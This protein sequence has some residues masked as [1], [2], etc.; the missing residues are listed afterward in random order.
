MQKEKLR[1]TT[2][3][4]KILHVCALGLAL[5]DFN[6]FRKKVHA[7]AGAGTFSG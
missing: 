4:F 1:R 7:H 5:P 3:F 2:G 6:A